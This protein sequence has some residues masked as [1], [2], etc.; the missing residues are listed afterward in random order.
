VYA[1]ERQTSSGDSGGWFE[2]EWLDIQKAL[3][4]A[5]VIKACINCLYS[6]Y[7]PYGHGLFGCMMCFRNIKDEYL[8]V[9]SKQSFWSVHGRQERMVQETYLCPDFARRIAGTGYR[10]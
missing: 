7:S 9:N 3:P 2:G 1:Q 10:G 4:E 8:R 6:D 5:V